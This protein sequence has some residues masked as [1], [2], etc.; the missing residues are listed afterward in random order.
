MFGRGCRLLSEDR[1]AG[2]L[3]MVLK[4]CVIVT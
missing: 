1:E 4:S 3:F 2:R